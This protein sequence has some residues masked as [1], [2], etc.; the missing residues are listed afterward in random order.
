M[1]DICNMFYFSLVQ[2][3]K[4]VFNY[5]EC[6]FAIWQKIDGFVF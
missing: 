2:L 6:L 4:F 5:V 1:A 3:K